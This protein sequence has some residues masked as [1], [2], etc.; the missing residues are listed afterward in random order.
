MSMSKAFLLIP[1]V[2]HVSACRSVFSSSDIL[3]ALWYFVAC[4]T[5]DVALCTNI[6][7]LAENELADRV[8]CDKVS[9]F[10]NLANETQLMWF[11]L[12]ML[13]CVMCV[14]FSV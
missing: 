3:Y 6:Q 11:V 2:P 5:S 8:F 7:A 1:L 14:S 12:C 9:T 13:V 10:S 4:E